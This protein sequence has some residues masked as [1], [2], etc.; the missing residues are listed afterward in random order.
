M[1]TWIPTRQLD[2]LPSKRSAKASKEETSPKNTPASS[3]QST[4]SGRTP[5][6]TAV[7]PLVPRAPWPKGVPLPSGRKGKFVSPSSPKKVISTPLIRDEV[8]FQAQARRLQT[9]R[10]SASYGT[11]V[12]PRGANVPTIST[13]LTE[14]YTDKGPF[15]HHLLRDSVSCDENEENMKETQA[16]QLITQSCRSSTCLVR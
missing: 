4:L 16:C 5:A 11:L 10:R 9:S 6:R 2:R 13:H 1:L 8:E 12:D 7:Q 14:E 3:R 15:S